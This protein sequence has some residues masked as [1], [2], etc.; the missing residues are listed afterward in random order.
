M[1]I[2]GRRWSAMLLTLALSAGNIGLCAG[3]TA[4]AEARMACCSDRPACPMSVSDSDDSHSHHGVTQEQADTCCAVSEGGTSSQSNP[5]FVVATNIAVVRT[6]HASP[7]VVPDLVLRNV[8]RLA[9]Q[10][11]P[12]SVPK[13][14]LHSVFIV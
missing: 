14:V 12:A 11:S 9:A 4:A 7:H 13:H 5:S 1:V 3:W 2:S 6:A 8:W 10:V